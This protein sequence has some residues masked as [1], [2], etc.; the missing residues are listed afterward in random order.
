M[1]AETNKN[2]TGEYDY[3]GKC[4]IYNDTD[5][6]ARDSVI[7][8]SIGD[9]SIESLFLAGGLFWMEGGKEYSRNSE[10]QVAHYANGGLDYVNY[11]YVYRHKVTKKRFR[12]K[13]ANGKSVIVTEDHSVMVQEGDKLVEKK[14]VELSVGDVIISVIYGDTV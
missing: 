4:V 6:V 9:I 11:N 3:L 2:I 14:P 1:A 7:R 13:T 12:I 8:T 5:S 10:I